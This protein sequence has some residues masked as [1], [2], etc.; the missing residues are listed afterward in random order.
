MSTGSL[1]NTKR[2]SRDDYISYSQRIYNILEQNNIEYFSPYYYDDKETFGDL[3]I[4]VKKPFGEKE[5]NSLF[6]PTK[7][8]YKVN[9][10]V[11][12]ICYKNFQIDFITV[13]PE[14][15]ETT[16]NYYSWADF[17]IIIGRLFKKM[18]LTFGF[19]GLV[20]KYETKINSQYRNIGEIFISDNIE[21]I[22]SF[23]NLDYSTFKKGFK[24]LN[25]I[26][27]Y[28]ISSKYFHPSYFSVKNDFTDRR[29]TLFNKLS[30]YT[31]KGDFNM[32]SFNADLVHMLI[33][34]HFKNINF[35]E[36][37]N[38]LK[39]KEKVV[40]TNSTKFN[41]DIVMTITGLKNKELGS[42]ISKFKNYIK[43]IY[44]FK[45]FDEY[46]YLTSENNINRDIKEFLKDN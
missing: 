39:E 34:E 9:G 7:T 2:I 23:L 10:S 31:I 6:K 41:G 14:K 32:I 3:D 42:F 4:I 33:D 5:I 46:V 44:S 21:E 18:N 37:I 16:K 30:D 13:K 20:Y 22:L 26:F 17:S 15:F 29:N 24:N 1:F 25:E 27:D 40:S 45:D 8:Q 36:K 38:Q 35:K 19:D 28:I 43:S 12:S 11:H